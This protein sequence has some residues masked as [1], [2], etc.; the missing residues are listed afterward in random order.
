M[1]VTP[2]IDPGVD[3]PTVDVSPY[4]P[5]IYKIAK[6]TF[7]GVRAQST[8]DTFNKGYLPTGTIIEEAIVTLAES[9]AW[10]HNGPDVIVP[11]DPNFVKAY[12]EEWTERQFKTTVRNKQIREIIVKGGGPERVAELIVSNLTASET[13]EDYN[14][15]KAIFTAILADAEVTK[16][17]AVTN[18]TGLIKAIKNVVKSFNRVN[19][20]YVPAN[21]ARMSDNSGIV[22][23][24]PD[25]ISTVIDVDVLS[26]AINPN[27][28]DYGNIDIATIDGFTSVFVVERNAILKYTNLDEFSEFYNGE[29]LFRNYFKTIS[30]LYGYSKLFKMTSIDASA[31][32][33]DVNTDTSAAKPV[34]VESST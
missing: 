23:V 4:I 16:Y 11:K 18:S 28:L 26:K 21:Y 5:L 1:A 7:A 32:A 31:I 6:Q 12:H 24:I 34:I 25:E 29:G 10:N 9:T 15:M 8:L 17:G 13:Y 33:T 22:V 19:T 2:I 27:P 3:V 14:S 20:T 30:R